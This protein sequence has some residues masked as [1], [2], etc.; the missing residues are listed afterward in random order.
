M[1]RGMTI[2]EEKDFQNRGNLA[3]AIFEKG[4]QKES[5]HRKTMAIWK[6]YDKDHRY[7][8]EKISRMV[9]SKGSDSKAF[10][11]GHSEVV[12]Q[13]NWE[14]KQHDDSRG[15]QIKLVKKRYR[16]LI[17]RYRTKFQDFNSTAGQKSPARGGPH[18]D[19][20]KT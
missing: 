2:L 5:Q 6:S 11:N 15:K 4:S 12:Q 19:G 16:N 8:K 18:G 20:S 1:R 10:K 3:T 7:L 13:M 9:D 17:N 14:R